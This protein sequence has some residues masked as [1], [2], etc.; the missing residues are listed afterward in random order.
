MVFKQ[1]ADLLDLQ[2]IHVIAPDHCVGV[3]HGNTG[4]HP[5]LAAY[6]HRLTDD[7]I[8]QTHHRD[9]VRLDGRGAHVHLDP[10]DHA[11]FYGQI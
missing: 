1:G 6:R 8:A 9:G 2:S 7:R 5:F 4:H 11:V 3:A 10:G